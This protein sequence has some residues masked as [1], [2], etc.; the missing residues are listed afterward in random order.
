[1]INAVNLYKGKTVA[2]IG[3]NGYIGSSLIEALSRHSEKV[4]RVCRSRLDPK[5]GMIDLQADITDPDCWQKIVHQANIIFY[6]AG[7]S[8]VY[9]SASDPSESLKSTLLPINHL[10]AA[11]QQSDNCPRVVLASTA[12]IYGLTKDLPVA[13]TNLA[14]P[15]TIYDLHKYFAEQQLALASC[16]GI[17]NSISL[18]LANVYGPSPSVSSAKDRGVLNRVSK[19][20][21]SGQ[22]LHVYGDGNYVRDYIYIDDVIEAFLLSGAYDS[23]AG[24]VFNVA[25]GIGHTLKEAF[26]LVA[27]SAVEL[28]GNRVKVSCFPWPDKTDPIE[29]RDFIG[30]IDAMYA[31]FKWCPEVSLS[32]GVRKMTNCFHVS[33]KS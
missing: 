18:R 1:M 3:A 21:L 4:I 20:A 29:H 9:A 26:E 10:I 14:N 27:V 19:I 11:A 7:N 2:V 23:N 30:N 17:I 31:A 12:T 5:P 32:L 8:S 24:Q 28:T 33:V 6:L 22:D 15:I 16:H 13:E 25:S